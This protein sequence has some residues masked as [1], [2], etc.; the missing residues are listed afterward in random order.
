MRAFFVLAAIGSLGLAGGFLLGS[1]ERPRTEM[2]LKAAAQ[3]MGHDKRISYVGY[4]C[5]DDGATILA[6][7]MDQIVGECRESV[8]LDE[9]TLIDEPLG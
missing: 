2:S 3:L 8:L 5:G 9:Q 1:Q 6:R 4:H 7:D